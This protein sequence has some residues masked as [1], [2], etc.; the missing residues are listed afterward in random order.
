MSI[1]LLDHLRAFVANQLGHCQQ[2]RTT[3][4]KGAYEV[5]A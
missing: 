1:V 4:H 3:S 5:V 2:G